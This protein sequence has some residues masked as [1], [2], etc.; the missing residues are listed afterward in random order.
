M[1]SALVCGAGG[2]IGSHLVK[3]LKGEG[4]W[5][6]GVDL[7]YPEFGGTDAT[8]AAMFLEAFRPESGF[9][10]RATTFT[11]DF[12]YEDCRNALGNCLADDFIL[13][14]VMYEYVPAFSE[15]HRAEIDG[16]GQFDAL[17]RHRVS[18]RAE[19]HCAGGYKCADDMPCV[20]VSIHFRLHRQV[21]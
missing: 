18:R 21:I 4:F 16:E 7:K 12:L 15:F 9:R 1:K 8:L 2:F 3:R 13:L 19:Q 11:P 14:A 17:R 5:V 10:D 6:R 20:H